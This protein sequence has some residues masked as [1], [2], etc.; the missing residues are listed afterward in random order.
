M[1][2]YREEKDFYTDEDFGKIPKG[3]TAKRLG[4]CFDFFPTAT[5]SRDYL[6]EDGEC[7]YI[8]Y[9]DIHTKFDGFIDF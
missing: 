9:G 1:L 4:D 8:H 3:W 5:Y 6:T 2:E 7:N